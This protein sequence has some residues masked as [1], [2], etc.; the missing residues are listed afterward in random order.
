M[1]IP[2]LF[3]LDSSGSMAGEK[4]NAVNEAMNE[5]KNIFDSLGESLAIRV[6]VVSFSIGCRWHTD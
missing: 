4:I 3:V 1:T 5:L 2:I 6:G